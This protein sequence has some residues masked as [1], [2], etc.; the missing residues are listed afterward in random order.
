MNFRRLGRKTHQHVVSFKTDNISRE[1][2]F[3]RASLK[4]R[5]DFTGGLELNDI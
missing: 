5:R 4:K 2:V 3:F 1:A